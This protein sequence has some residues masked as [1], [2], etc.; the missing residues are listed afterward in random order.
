MHHLRKVAFVFLVSAVGG[1]LPHASDDWRPPCTGQTCVLMLLLANARVGAARRPYRSRAAAECDLS[2][3]DCSQRP[4]AG[5]TLRRSFAGDCASILV[6]SQ[7]PVDGAA[8]R[9]ARRAARRPQSGPAVASRRSARRWC[10]GAA[11][12]IRYEIVWSRGGAWQRFMRSSGGSGGHP[13]ASDVSL[14]RPHPT[15]SAGRG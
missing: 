9:H 2:H 1:H 4:A 13:R 5:R 11:R 7:V 10:E 12:R 8:S 14:G 3:A 15:G 6:A